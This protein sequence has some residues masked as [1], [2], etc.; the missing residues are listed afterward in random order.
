[1]YVLVIRSHDTIDCQ[2]SAAGRIYF[3]DRFWSIGG[4]VNFSILNVVKTTLNFL[5]SSMDRDQVVTFCFISCS[6]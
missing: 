1:M 2:S 5:G 6:C 4:N 3:E